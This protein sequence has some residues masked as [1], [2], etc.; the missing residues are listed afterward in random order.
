MQWNG[1]KGRWKPTRRG[2]VMGMAASGIAASLER[3]GLSE[4]RVSRRPMVAE[5]RGTDFEL[6]VEELAVNLTGKRRRATV[7]N[8]SLPGPTRSAGFTI[9]VCLYGLCAP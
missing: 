8:G 1:S 6:T 5:L 2:F 3:V 4:T 9:T 7:V